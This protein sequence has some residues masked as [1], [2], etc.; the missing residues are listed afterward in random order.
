M[1]AAN[2]AGGEMSGVFEVTLPAMALVQSDGFEEILVGELRGYAN[3]NADYTLKGPFSGT[4]NGTANRDGEV[5][6]T[7]DSGLDVRRNIG[8]QRARM[9]GTNTLSGIWQGREYVSALGWGKDANEAN[10]RATL[11]KG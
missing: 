6:M 10:L 1:I 11:A 7:C 5:T 8:R 4:C 9:T 2:Q 3:G